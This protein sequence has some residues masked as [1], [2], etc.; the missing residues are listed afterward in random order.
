ML[1]RKGTVLSLRQRSSE[2][3][4]REREGPA[5]TGKWQRE[6][7]GLLSL[8]AQ[9]VK[10]LFPAPVWAHCCSSL[11]DNQS[12]GGAGRRPGQL[13]GQ[14][15]PLC[16]GRSLPR[17]ASRGQASR[18]AEPGGSPPDTR[19]YCPSLGWNCSLRPAW[20]PF[21]PRRSFR[22]PEQVP[23]HMDLGLTP[24]GLWSL[25]ALGQGRL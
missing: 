10:L 13:P 3:A 15:G 9:V 1:S 24:G 22:S 21:L 20:S 23:G 14:R 7:G 4:A 25:C 16:F 17:P 6:A 18:Y 5:T 2:K 19:D 12:L 11:H 8:E